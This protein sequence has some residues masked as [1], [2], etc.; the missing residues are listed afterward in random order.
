MFLLDQVFCDKGKFR[1]NESSL[2]GQIV[3]T[4][5]RGLLRKLQIKTN[6][7]LGRLNIRCSKYMCCHK[8][9]GQIE[10]FLS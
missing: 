7:C 3:V 8:I 5:F 1:Y 9:A 6:I 10:T 4:S 2:V